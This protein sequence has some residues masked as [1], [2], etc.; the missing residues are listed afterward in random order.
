VT[1]GSRGQGGAPDPEGQR[2]PDQ[3]FILVAEAS[4]PDLVRAVHAQGQL[5]AVV[6]ADPAR[7][8]HVVPCPAFADLDTALRAV[9]ATSVC[10][11]A[12]RRDLPAQVQTCV[13][14]GV[15]V[16]ALGPP[17][18]S[19]DRYVRLADQAQQNGVALAWGGW[20]SSS[21][22][23]QQALRQSN[24]D[25]F[26]EPVYLR[27]VSAGGHSALSTWWTA[28]E[29]LAVARLL[30]GADLQK[31]WIAATRARRAYHAVVTAVAANAASAQLVIAPSG[32]AGRLDFLL[33][34]SGGLL[35]STGPD[36]A[37]R[38][39]ASPPA[40]P[41]DAP[42]PIEAGWLADFPRPVAA[43]LPPLPD[44]HAFAADRKVLHAL[45]RS[46]RCG[47]P[48]ALPPSPSAARG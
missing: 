13:D 40:P 6:S 42:G 9:S 48:V 26:G 10:F 19:T 44:A 29:L 14:R 37:A 34:G 23:V 39:F 1:P 35:D 7:L 2:G 41:A 32:W 3:G 11:A 31:V 38:T 18:M 46:A 47:R 43:A 22:V 25:G 24:Q 17:D 21:A 5:G 45:R 8:E 20:Q 28:R 12:V 27:C 30:L 15:H 36:Q 16:L 33:L 4:Q